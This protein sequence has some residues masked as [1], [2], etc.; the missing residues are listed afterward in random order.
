MVR[1]LGASYERIEIKDLGDVIYYQ[2]QKEYTDQQFRSSKDLKKE[3]DSGRI[4]KIK[5][6]SAPSVSISEDVVYTPAQTSISTPSIPFTL[7]DIKSVVS[8]SLKSVKDLIGTLGPVIA[9]AVKQEIARIPS[10]TVSSSSMDVSKKSDFIGPE[11]IPNIS[12]DG[13][14]ASIEIKE[15]SSS[16]DSILDNVEALRRL[17]K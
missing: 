15:K 2:Q 8:D 5:E 16:G 13:M 9:E 12:T 3:L 11:Y 14:K 4:I 1:V 17:K 7:S 6:I 10:I